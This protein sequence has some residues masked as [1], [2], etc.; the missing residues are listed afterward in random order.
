M[1][2]DVL[3]AGAVQAVIVGRKFGE[4]SK[5]APSR[6]HRKI[7]MV[8]SIAVALSTLQNRQGSVEDEKIIPA[9]VVGR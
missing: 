4:E 9:P 1:L 7:T 8:V 5:D 6:S 3:K 2:A